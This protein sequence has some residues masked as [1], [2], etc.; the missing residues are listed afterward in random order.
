MENEKRNAKYD[1]IMVLSR[2]QGTVYYQAL[3][4]FGRGSTLGSLE[5][6]FLWPTNKLDR[7]QHS[8]N[9]AFVSE[10]K[11]NE[12]LDKERIH[13]LDH[14]PKVRRLLLVEEATLPRSIYTAFQPHYLALSSARNFL[15][16][17]GHFFEE[18]E[19]LV[20]S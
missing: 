17:S 2:E 12:E 19:A 11:A 6:G 8:F 5:V 20:V 14:K 9:I 7:Q 10:K 1:T 3:F 15:I 13:G 16:Q 18:P 4:G